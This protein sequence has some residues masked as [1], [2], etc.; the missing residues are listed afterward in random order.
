MKF[1]ITYTTFTGEVKEVIKEFNNSPDA[2]ITAAEWAND[3]AYTM[4]DKG[5]YSIEALIVKD[6][7]CH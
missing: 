5:D 3:Y 6:K 4:S 2:D 7:L 1:K